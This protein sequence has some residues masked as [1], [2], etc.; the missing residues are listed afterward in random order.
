MLH[1][2][3][4]SCFFL[5]LVL[6]RQGW[7]GLQDILIISK[8]PPYP[9]CLLPHSLSFSRSLISSRC[10]CVPFPINSR[11]QRVSSRS[12]P[13]FLYRTKITKREGRVW[14]ATQPFSHSVRRFH[15]HGDASV[16]GGEWRGGEEKFFRIRHYE[17]QLAPDR[18]P[19]FGCHVFIGCCGMPQFGSYISLLAVGDLSLM[20]LS[21][22]HGVDNKN[23]KISL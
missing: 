15:Q 6:R 11:R 9:S 22:V 13:W 8:Q 18:A 4:P 1:L 19:A 23:F 2:F 10:K 20:N 7:L 3:P 21:T 16:T 17:L 5:F 12:R 14:E